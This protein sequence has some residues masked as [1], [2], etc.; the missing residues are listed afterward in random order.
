MKA[1]VLAGGYAK[2]LWPL[3]LNKAKPLLE[4]GGKPIINYIIE[5]LEKND[6]ITE[7]IISTNAKFEPVF[8]E[9]VQKYGFDKLKFVIEETHSENEKFGAIAGINF[10]I[11][12]AN[13]DEDCIILAGDN[14]FSFDI[15]DF[16]ALFK[17]KSAPVLAVFDVKD[18]ELAKK[19]GIAA[20]DDSNKVVGFEEKP[21]NPKSTLASTGCYVFPKATLELFAEYLDQSDKKD[22]P[23][24]FLQ[25][26]Y[27][28][29]DVF[30]FKFS[31]YWFDIG[32]LEALDEAREF[33]KK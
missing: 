8:K 20:L 29:Q 16:I 12:L 23:G 27:K 4:V 2:R 1:L 26:L 11:K 31:D 18:K 24:F 9:W 33:M 14:L 25:W 32:S 10:A 19:Y 30:A 15:N 21:E 7:I 3:T 13:I 28:K 17:E 5:K 22:A 6:E